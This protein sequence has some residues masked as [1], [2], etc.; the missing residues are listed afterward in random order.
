MINSIE[1][2]CPQG[3][4]QKVQIGNLEKHTTQSCPSKSFACQLC[5]FTGKQAEFKL[6]ILEKHQDQLTQFF[7]KA[8]PQPQVGAGAS[9]STS[10]SASIQFDRIA[11]TKNGAGLTAKLGESGKYYC[12]GRQDGARCQCCD[13]YCGPDNGCNCSQCMTLDVKGRVLQKGYLVN[14]EGRTAR[15]GTTGQFYCGSKVLFGVPGCDGYCGPTNG[16]N[17]GPCKLLTIQAQDRYK[18]LV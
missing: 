4:G 6:H 7:Q 15:K 2:E 3:C 5:P 18:S 12:G 13:G 1:V 16:P 9:S 11:R 8:P 10:D 14:K 17:C